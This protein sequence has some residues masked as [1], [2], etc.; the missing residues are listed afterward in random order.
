MKVVTILGTRPAI[1]RLSCT[2][3]LLDRHVDHS[4]VHTG[5][6]WDYELNEI[7]FKDLNVR[8]PDHF[9]NVDT[10]S[11][12]RVYGGILIAAEEI[13]KKERPDAVLILGDTNSSIAGIM[14][15]RMKI[16]LFHMEAGNRCFDFNVPEEINRRIIDHI[17]DFNLCY[18]EHARR[19]LLSEGMPHRRVYVTGSPMREV[20][21]THVERIQSSAV[22]KELGLKKGEFFLASIHREENVDRREGLTSLIAALESL[23][24]K[25]GFPVIVSTHPRTRKRLEALGRSDISENIRFMKPFGFLDY[26]N[27]QMHAACVLSDSG[28]ICEESSMLDFPAV[29]VRCALERPEAMDAG[30]IVLT[31]LDD[32]VIVKAVEV[33]MSADIREKGMCIPEDYRITNTSHRVLKIILGTAKLSNSWHGIQYNDLV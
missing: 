20:L 24:K 30:S 6:N 18:T 25:F 33:Q 29:T 15:K 17:S 12:G 26:V 31:G 13:L 16:P 22:L 9:M 1:I 23:S 32:G 28:T 4:I 2:M 5:Q 27:L 7:F 21:D 3:A 14:A 19:H 10:T 11:L 8:K